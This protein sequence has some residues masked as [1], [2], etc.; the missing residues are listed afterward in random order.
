MTQ[1]GEISMI[2]VWLSVFGFIFLI[3]SSDSLSAPVPDT[4]QTKFYNNTVEISQPSPEQPFYGQDA[5]YAVNPTSYTK[6][7]VSGN[8]LPDSAESWVMV[9]DNVTGL[10]WEEKQNMDGA[11]NYANPHDADN[12][13]NWYNS[14]PDTNRGN[15]GNF[16]SGANTENFIK[17]LNDT[18]FGGYSDWRLPSIKEL[19][20]LA[21]RDA[22]YPSINKNYF[23]NTKSS[24]AWSDSFGYWSSNTYAWDTTQAWVLNFSYSN[25][26]PTDKSTASRFVRA[27]RGGN[28]EPLDRYVVNNGTVTDAYTGLIWEQNSSEKALTWEEALAYCENLSL[29]GNT[30]WRLPNINELNSLVD[31]N[32]D[33]AL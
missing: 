31:Y 2:K 32:L 23:P 4:G 13:F 16:G 30:D 6:L 28:P 21:N 12:T 14:N 1:N 20:E 3:V 9:R 22:F 29:A 10:V 19:N 25:G 26:N 33:F 8:I 24:A 15:P 11:V 17:A 18:H 7:D 5:N 27:V